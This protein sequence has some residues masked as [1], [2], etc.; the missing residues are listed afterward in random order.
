MQSYLII[1]AVSAVLSFGAG[2]TANGWKHDAALLD[3]ALSYADAIVAEQEKV[4]QL[5]TDLEAERQTKAPKERI[6]TRE[7]TRYVQVVPVVDRCTLPGQWRLLH[8]AAATGEPPSSPS[9]DDAGST[10]IEDAAA[11]ETVAENY[12]A[13]R[14]WRGQLIGLQRY[15]K[16]VCLK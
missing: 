2:W 8:D 4:D 7:V 3:Q 5:S 6:I 12:Q 15:V 10:P 11:L 1:A 14:E 9:L 13:C 16:D